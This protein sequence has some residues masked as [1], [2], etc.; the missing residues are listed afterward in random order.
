MKQLRCLSG[1]ENRNRMLLIA[2]GFLLLVLFV[3]CSFVRDD[4][5]FPI[6]HERSYEVFQYFALTAA[7]ADKSIFY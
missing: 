3:Y 7:R 1:V 5:S 6:Y 2:V 4:H